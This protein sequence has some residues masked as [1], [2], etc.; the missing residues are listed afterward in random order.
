MTDDLDE[1]KGRA[2]LLAAQYR[3][4]TALTLAAPLRVTVYV[5]EGCDCPQQGG[6]FHIHAFDA[7]S[8]AYW[9]ETHPALRIV[10]ECPA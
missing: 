2:A 6:P 7:R 4:T 1:A 3:A 10:A 9:Q 5:I 8:M